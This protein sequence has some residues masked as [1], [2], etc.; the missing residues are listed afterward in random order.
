[1][2]WW[3]WL[4]FF[5]FCLTLTGGSAYLLY[6]AWKQQVYIPV[7]WLIFGLTCLLLFVTGFVLYEWYQDSK[8]SKLQDDSFCHDVAA[9]NQLDDWNK[10]TDLRYI[11]NTKSVTKDK[12]EQDKLD[13]LM[14]EYRVQFREKLQQHMNNLKNSQSIGEWNEH[15][16]KI[17]EMTKKLHTY[18]RTIPQFSRIEQDLKQFLQEQK[19]IEQ[20]WKT[21]KQEQ[22]KPIGY[23]FKGKKKIWSERK[24]TNKWG[25]RSVPRWPSTVGLRQK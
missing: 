3:K 6:Y 9:I 17:N 21:E 1:M 5:V 23:E 7:L 13:A 2:E 15:V 12:C 11:Y 14:E 24:K 19:G 22:F 10:L 8:R 25:I 18:L 20:Q 4:L 16:N